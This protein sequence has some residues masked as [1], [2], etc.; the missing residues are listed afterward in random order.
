MFKWKSAPADAKEKEKEERKLN[1]KHYVDRQRVVY[2]L[3]KAFQ[4]TPNGEI[5]RHEKH[6]GNKLECSHEGCDKKF[7][8]KHTLKSHIDSEHKG[9]RIVCEFDYLA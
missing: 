5:Y 3:R 1:D 9:I 2:H 4:N 7:G 6:C 8:S